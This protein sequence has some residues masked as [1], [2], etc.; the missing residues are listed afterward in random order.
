MP[1]KKPASANEIIKRLESAFD[2]ID[3]AMDEANKLSSHDPS[4]CAKQFR[5]DL[6]S[7]KTPKQI[8]DAHLKYVRCMATAVKRPTR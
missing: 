3:K 7:A 5:E 1:P 2:D 4:K 6:K 8:A